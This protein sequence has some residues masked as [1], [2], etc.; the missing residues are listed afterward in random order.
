MRAEERE[1]E[2]QALEREQGL[3]EEVEHEEELPVLGGA[4]LR[5]VE[6][7]HRS[8]LFD[9]LRLVLDGERVSIDALFLPAR[10]TSALAALQTAVEGHD[11]IGE[12]VFAEDRRALLE[13]ALAVLQQ[14]ITHGDPAQLAELH[15]KFDEMSE[16]VGALRE[17]L[18][19]L[20]D[21]QE[22]IFR[23]Y[24]PIEKAAEG[25]TGDQD[26]AP[27]E[28]APVIEAPERPSAPVIEAPERPSA[29]A[30]EGAKKEKKKEK[31]KKKDK[32]K[33]KDKKKGKKEKASLKTEQA[34]AASAAATPPSALAGETLPERTAAATTLIGDALPEE[35]AAAPT[36]L[37]GEELPE[38]PAQPSTLVGEE[39][40]EPA[41]AQNT[42]GFDDSD[43]R[44]WWSK[45][46]G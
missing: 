7:A 34:A 28:S 13:Q 43:K 24:R 3:E 9:A 11:A 22:E 46:L 17:R 29:P 4:E 38:D 45:L 33:E 1:L 40:P 15:A 14:N 10:E 6:L 20:E 18:T 44:P 31:E 8:V 5:D 32:E 35:T 26:D 12:F 41:P 39:L 19:N 25:D 36:T 37:I 27:R 30:I 16:R 2:G 42:L 23:E 21:A